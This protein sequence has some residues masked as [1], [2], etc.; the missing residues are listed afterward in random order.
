M[1]ARCL[2]C[3][4]YVDFRAQRGARLADHRCSCTGKLELVSPRMFAAGS[5]FIWLYTNSAGEKFKYDQDA[6]KFTPFKPAKR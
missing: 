2:L 5:D 3:N 6:K 1:N 4:A